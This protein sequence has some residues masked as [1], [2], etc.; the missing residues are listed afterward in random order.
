MWAYE[1][2]VQR[3]A[4]DPGRARALLREAGWKPGPDGIATKDGHTLSAVLAFASNNVTAR[5]ISVQLQ[6]YLRAVGID[7]E[8]KGYS[9]AMMFAG[10]AA[11]GV[12]QGGNYDLAWYTMTLGVDPNSA[13]RFS[14]NAIPPA[15]QNYSRYCAKEMDAAQKAGLATYERSAR[16]RAYSESQRLL[17]RDVPIVFI[18]WPKDMEAFTPRLHGLAPNPATP[19]W[20]AYAW[21]LR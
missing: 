10:Y 1:P 11:G 5:L 13:G 20:N 14:C 6:G 7:V 4:Y 16:K 2:N 21:E 3:Y 9:N 12:F 8:L 19:S 18:Y 15:G 17:A